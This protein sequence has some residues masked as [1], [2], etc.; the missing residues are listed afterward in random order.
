MILPTLPRVVRP[1]ESFDLPVSVFVNRADI[2]SVQVQVEPGAMFRVNGPQIRTVEFSK[3][4][5]E[6]VSFPMTTVQAIGQGSV[7]I[8]AVAGTR[9]AESRVAMPVLAANPRILE[10]LRAE[11]GP[12]E[13]REIPVKAFGL[14]GTNDVTL[15]FSMLPPFDLQKRLQFLIQYPHGCLE[16]TLSTAFPQ[17]YL[18]YLMKLDAGQQKK[19]DNFIAVAIEKMRGFQA[20]NGGFSYWP[21]AYEVHQWTSSY[22]GY[23]LLEAARLGYHVPAGMLDLWKKNQKALANSWT[24]APRRAAWSRRSACSRWPSP[25][26]R[27]WAP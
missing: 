23:F 25:A 17:L 10:T 27:T 1:G 14:K 7:Y 9:K 18:K 24:A 22:A 4:G 11:I 21:G 16:Q 15:E 20:P 12:G 8:K 2:R 19:V 13:S 6:I 5:D 26:R 3:P